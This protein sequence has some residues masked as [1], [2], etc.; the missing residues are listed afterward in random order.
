MLLVTRGVPFQIHG[1]KLR[2]AVSWL[3]P[4]T[5]ILDFDTLPVTNSFLC[6]FCPLL[7]GLFGRQLISIYRFR[8]S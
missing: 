5:F 2:L 8:L 4:T 7:V 3:V 6:S 1:G